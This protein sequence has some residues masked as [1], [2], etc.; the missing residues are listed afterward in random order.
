[1]FGTATPLKDIRRSDELCDWLEQRGIAVS[2][3]IRQAV[4]SSGLRGSHVH[5][6]GN[7]FDIMRRRFSLLEIVFLSDL[8]DLINDLQDACRTYSHTH[9]AGLILTVP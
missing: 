8:C 2:L 5:R 9:F 4:I 6:H 3:T 7:R 1:M